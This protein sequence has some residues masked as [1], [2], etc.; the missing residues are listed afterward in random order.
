MLSM[1]TPSNAQAPLSLLIQAAHDDGL[2]AQL[3]QDPAAALSLHGI[4]VDARDLPAD[5]TLPAKAECERFAG[6]GPGPVWVGYS[7]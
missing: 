7:V 2:R 5:V 3:E 4:Q 1:E 6:D